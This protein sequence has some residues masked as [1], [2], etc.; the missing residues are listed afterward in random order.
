MKGKIKAFLALA[1]LGFSLAAVWDFQ[2]KRSAPVARMIAS[3]PSV[4][5]PAKVSY[6]PQSRAKPVQEKAS[7]AKEPRPKEPQSDAWKV[8]RERFGTEL[9]GEFL[10]DGRLVSARQRRG[11]PRGA[12]TSTSS[13]S[14][15]QRVIARAKEILH[16][17]QPLLGV[18]LDSSLG[19]PVSTINEFSAQVRF[20]QVHEGI[21]VFPEGGIRISFARD[22]ALVA[23]ESSYVPQVVPKNS[24]QMGANEARERVLSTIAD[25]GLNA[26]K[27]GEGSP[28]VWIPTAGNGSGALHAYEFWAEG[29]QILV[30]AESGSVITLRDRRV[31]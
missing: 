15:P 24:I 18:E 5:E 17:A 19:T 9:E 16:A 7:H 2:S 8:F 14:D 1:T 20:P 6:A 22:G 21:P 31:F 25:R 28:L 4:S 12:S 30:D 13:L 3:S 10:P 23:L 27:V 11:S 29:R 26:R